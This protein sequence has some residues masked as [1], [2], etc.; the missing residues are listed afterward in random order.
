MCFFQHG[1]TH[2]IV[3]GDFNVSRRV[4]ELVGGSSKISVAMEE[5]DSCLQSAELNDLRFSGFLHTWC[6]K[7]SN[8]CISKKLD[9]ILVNKEWMAKFEHS[10]AFF[11]PPSIS[12]HSPSLV[13]LG[14]QGNKKNCPFKIFNFLTERGDFL[15][16]VE[17]CWQENFHGNMQFQLCYKLRNLKKALKSLNKNTVGDVTVKSIEAKAALVEC[18]R[19]LDLQPLDASLRIQKKE[20]MSSYTLAVQTEEE[21][22]LRQKSRVQWLKAGDRNSSYF[23]KAIKERRNRSKILSISGEDDSLIEGD[24]RVKS[25]AIGHFQN[26]LGCSMPSRH[27]SRSLRNVIDK[28]ISNDQVDYMSREV[29]ND[30]I[31][32]A[33]FSLHPNKAPGPDGFNAYFFNKTW[34]IVGDN[35]INAIQEFFHSGLLL[36]ELN[37]TTLAL[38]LKIIAKIIA[39][40][41]KPCLPDIISPSQSAF[42]AGKRIGD[43]ILLVQELKRDYHKDA[44]MPKLALKVDLMKAFDMVDLGFLLDTLAAFHFPLKVINWIKACLTT[45]K[46]SIY[47]NGE[48]AGFF[49]GKRALR[50]GNPMSPYL[51]VIAMEVLSKLLA[52]HIMDT[53]NF[54]Y[55]WSSCAQVSP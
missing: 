52:N 51:F 31:R 42:V 53:P 39:N 30:E 10:E 4:Q 16:L 41:I 44:S 24:T 32:E 17:S 13:K 49:S 11:L 47:I 12:D 43:N 15:P 55:H 28:H 50:Q 1:G 36:K 38:V 27:G 23:F 3:V 25:E 29:T 40:R 9:R 5:F 18:Q 48:L 54:K 21:D 35:V 22:F 20:L 7:R 45:P 6:N 46:F 33:C 37:A 8:G 2:W 19:N 34:H 26:I 14:L